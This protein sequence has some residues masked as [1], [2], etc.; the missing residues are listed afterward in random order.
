MRS[1]I[2]LGTLL[3]A[4]PLALVATPA[5]A[6]TTSA[7]VSTDTGATMN[8][9]TASEDD[10]TIP[11]ALV[12]GA[13]VGPIFPQPFSALDTHVAFGLELGY[14]LPFA[15]QRLEIMLDA[16]Y[17]PPHNSFKL[18]RVEKGDAYNA[19]LAEEELHFS[20]GPRVHVMERSSPWNVTIAA[21][22][23]L[24]LLRS[25]SNG[26][27]GGE[28]FAEFYEQSTKLGFFAALGGEYILGPGALFLDVD[29][30]YA[31]LDHKITGDSSTGNITPTI[32]YRFF[33]L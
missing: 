22:G 28:N 17:S 11:G 5:L 12:I 2:L 25:Y 24:F 27:R 3:S 4:A 15:E 23:R 10:P 31:K 16:G 32:G 30:G 14:R 21:G 18:V 19:T 29:L 8:T 26:S 9:D 13:E 20:L 7:S 1:T 6:E 33:L